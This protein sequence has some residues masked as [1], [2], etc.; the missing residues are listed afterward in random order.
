MASFAVA[1][2]LTLGP[3][4]EHVIDGQFQTSFSKLSLLK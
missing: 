3:G 1:N 4:F 2:M